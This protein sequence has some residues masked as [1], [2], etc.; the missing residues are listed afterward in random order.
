M[1]RLPQTFNKR[2]EA[3]ARRFP[4]KIAFRL[5]TPEGYRTYS[6]REAYRQS[7]AV[8]QS[9]IALGLQ[10]GARVAILSENRPEWVIAYLGSYLARMIAV[11]L[12]TQISRQEWR[13]LLEDSQSQVV[14]VS[15]LLLSDLKEAVKDLRPMPRIICFDSLDGDRDARNEITGL[16]EWAEGLAPPPL[17]PSEHPLLPEP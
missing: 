6:Y 4:D 10:Q 2:F 13:R 7:R 8:A 1:D 14:F 15:G 11:P 12:D 5:K 3:T 9:L 16:I 17:L